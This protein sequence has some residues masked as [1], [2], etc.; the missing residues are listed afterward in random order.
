MQHLLARL[1][2]V[3]EGGQRTKSCRVGAMHALCYVSREDEKGPKALN[4][5]SSR[6]S[7]TFGGGRTIFPAPQAR[8]G[9]PEPAVGVLDP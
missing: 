2:R 9:G 5:L 4:T 6:T 8:D 1:F 3:R 7:H